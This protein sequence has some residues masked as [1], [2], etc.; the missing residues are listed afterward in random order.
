MKAFF[1]F[2]LL[3][4]MI[5][6]SCKGQQKQTPDYSKIVFVDSTINSFDS[7]IVRF[8]GSPIYV[9]IWA[10][11]CSPCR[12]EFKHVSKIMGLLDSVKAVKLYIS[13]DKLTAH[14]KW[15]Q[16]V[17]DNNLTGYHIRMSDSLKKDI[18]RLFARPLKS[19]G[20][21]ALIYPTYLLINSD[22]VVI[23]KNAPKPSEI[24]DLTN[25]FKNV[26][27]Q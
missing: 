6:Q 21:L 4:F 12:R 1:G 10:T 8:K 5:F 9:D 2:I 25:V 17:Y 24:N 22:G 20:E 3:V 7:L 11:W 15:E 18:T 23:N 13:G 27:K 14:D 26:S 16:V 19:S